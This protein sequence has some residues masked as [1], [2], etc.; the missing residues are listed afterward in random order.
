[1]RHCPRCPRNLLGD[2]RMCWV[3]G[4]P[5]SPG[6]LAAATVLGDD[7]DRE[8]RRWPLAAAGAAGVAALAAVIVAGVAFGHSLSAG[9]TATA[10]PL[11]VIDAPSATLTAGETDPA[12]APP[13]G[14]ATGAAPPSTPASAAATTDPAPGT[15]PATRDELR[16]D[17]ADL[18]RYATELRA[19]L[20]SGASAAAR[21]PLES[22]VD[23]GGDI[24][25]ALATFDDR[26]AAQA[27]ACASA[28]LSDHPACTTTGLTADYDDV[29][30]SV[31]AARD[32][33]T[34]QLDDAP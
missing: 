27:Q 23:P 31:L 16:T 19:A 1:M 3:C 21:P 26:R 4:T 20:L 10:A 28:G 13:T 25:V 22:R 15:T 12:T 30:A 5:S 17:L 34:A 14:E 24:A 18:D 29:A 33:L 7:V 2:P 9:L 32:E 8:R 11:P 6:E